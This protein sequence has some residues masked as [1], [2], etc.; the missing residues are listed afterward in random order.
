MLSSEQMVIGTLLGDR[1]TLPTIRAEVNASHFRTEEGRCIF[2]VACALADEGK[3]IDPVL[4]RQRAA[5][6]RSDLNVEYMIDSMNYAASAAS[7]QTHLDGMKREAFRADMLDALAGAQVRLM[8]GETPQMICTDLQTDIQKAIEAD[9]S[10]Q[11][12]TS[13][14]AMLRFMDHRLQIESGQRKAFIPTG[15]NSLDNALGGGMVP[16]GLYILAARPGCGKTTL[17]LQIAENVAQRGIST[18][19]I[20]LEMSVDQL[21]ARRVAVKT[22]IPSGDILMKTLD[23]EQCEA[24]AKAVEELSKRPLSF[25]SVRKAGV[26]NIGILARQVKNCGLVVVDYLG[27]LQYES[28]KTLYEQVTKTSNALKRLAC[29][30][31]I[32]ILCLA[33]LNREFEGRKGPPRLSDLRDS[34]AIE[35]DADGVMLLHRPPVELESESTPALLICT[36]AKNRHGPMGKDVEMNWYLTNGRIRSAVN[37]RV[38]P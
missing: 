3:K 13:E 25:N 1:R 19:F 33:Q 17:G 16:E 6:K 31:G 18:L 15:F 38:I 32:P 12:I 11:I 36:V 4:I 23:S 21:T 20:S 27:L 5:E 37:E 35:Q 9:N 28:G 2:E 22:G 14:E 34:G 29:S 10:H 8:S 7:L 30:L 26:S 24:M